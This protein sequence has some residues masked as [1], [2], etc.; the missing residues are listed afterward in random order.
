MFIVWRVIAR[1][2]GVIAVA[3]ALA[4]GGGVL[5]QLTFPAGRDSL[6]LF[7][8]HDLA[9][10][11]PDGKLWARNGGG[12]KVVLW[13]LAARKEMA[14]LTHRGEVGFLAFDPAGRTLVAWFTE[15][16]ANRNGERSDDI[17][18]WDVASFEKRS[19]G[20]WPDTKIPEMAISPDGKTLATVSM[21]LPVRPGGQKFPGATSQEVK[22]WDLSSGRELKL[23]DQSKAARVAFSPDG[24]WLATFH[25]ESGQNGQVIFWNAATLDPVRKL[26]IEGGYGG[27]QLAFSLDSK[28]IAAS[29]F[30]HN[31][32]PD[33]KTGVTVW[34]V[35]T[36]K[37]TGRLP[38]ISRSGLPQQGTL[39]EFSP[40]GL[41]LVIGKRN[42][43]Q[44]RRGIEQ[45]GIA[46]IHLWN[47][48]TAEDV[49]LD[50][51][52]AGDLDAR[53]SPDGRYLATTCDVQ[54]GAQLLGGIKLW[55]T[56]YWRLARTLAMTSERGA[57]RTRFGTVAWQPRF[58]PDRHWLSAI[59]QDGAEK[60][61][62]FT[63]YLWELPENPTVGAS[64]YIPGSDA[65]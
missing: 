13:D 7:V 39:V 17:V 15:F 2:S 44:G 29:C 52:R 12:G 54:E 47:H 36:G 56:K 32:K 48:S 31:E 21:R 3:L 9:A 6:N 35:E 62:A 41:R 51:G 60:Q 49:L 55:D 1:Y 5:A 61:N 14:T 37:V 46:E 20:K 24:R 63:F 27:C 23:L 8:T 50:V 57:A 30:R 33:G 34:D 53:F 16:A 22:I 42:V 19:L 43:L 18:V 59:C 10:F 65:R 25:T 45:S 38:G 26:K 64:G 40:D 11:S 4:P 28:Q 58:S